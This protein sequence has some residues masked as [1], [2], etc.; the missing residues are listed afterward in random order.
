MIGSER[1]AYLFLSL[2]QARTGS[3]LIA[4]L[5]EF[6]PSSILEMPANELAAHVKMT[7]RAVQVFEELRRDFDPD[8]MVG[9]LEKRGRKVFTPV[10]E[11]YPVRLCEMPD[12]TPALFVDSHLPKAP[13]A[14]IVGSRKA[15]PTGLGA[16]RE[17]GRALGERGVCVVSGLAL[18]IDAASHQ[19]A[20]DGGGPTAGVLGCGVDVANAPIDK[21]Q[22]TSGDKHVS[23]VVRAIW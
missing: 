11:E 1:S 19:G 3:S 14:A 22:I 16:A 12:P 4:R 7:A 13:T 10:D 9:C 17:L 23:P 5:G 15:S 18:G 8:S 20:L 2:L 6:S 21:P